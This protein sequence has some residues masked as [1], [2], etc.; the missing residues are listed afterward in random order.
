M[1]LRIEGLN[2]AVGKTHILHDINLEVRTGEFFCILGNSGCG[3]STLLKTIAGFMQEQTGEMMLDD[4]ALHTLA[5]QKRGTVVVFQDIRLFS[6]MTVG[7]NVAYP[8]RIR[9]TRKA[10]RL[11]AAEGYL[12]L[13]QLSGFAGRRVD[14]LSGG[15]AQRVALARALAAEPRLLLLDEPFSSLDENLRD[16][17]RRLVLDIHEKT[18]LTTVMVTH[19]QREALAMSDRLAVV[20]E[21]RIVQVGTPDEVYER[22][23]SLEIARYFAD[24]DMI[25]G[26]VKGGV[27]AAGG[28]RIQAACADGRAVAIIRANAVRLGSEGDLF[29]VRALEYHGQTFRATLERE[30]V[31]IHASYAPDGRPQVGGR[32]HVSLDPERVLFFPRGDI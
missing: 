7:E 2:V 25:E 26:E 8:M 20:S 22:P 13:V 28:I 4:V 10:D 27:F 3:K 23:A 6:N 19:D 15:Q 24:G 1:T 9:K 31:C 16:D 17:M 5:P 29:S 11:K 30:G 14:E 12:E 21:G 32:V 18:G